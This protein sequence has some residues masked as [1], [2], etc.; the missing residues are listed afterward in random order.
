MSVNSR[1]TKFISNIELTE[2]QKV[3][4]AER[5]EKVIE[6]LNRHYWASSSKTANSKYV[7]S[8]GKLT[9]VRP[10]RDVDVLFQLP[11]S[12]YNR[13]QL[14]TGNRQSQLL[15][16]VKGVLASKFT[17]TAVKGS[18][19]I[20]E[21]PFASYNVEVVPAFILTDKKYWVCMT[22]D[23]GE[24]KVADYD[25]E[26]EIIRASN[27]NCNGNTRNLIRMIKR[28]Q[29]HCDVPIKSFW[30]E[31]IAVE[32]LNQ[33]EYRDKSMTYYDWMVRD[34][35]EF[36]A[37]KEFATLYAPGTYEAMYLGSAWTAKARA[38][39]KHAVNACNDEKDYPHLAGGSWQ[40]IFG[41]DIPLGG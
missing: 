9:R 19:P 4:G 12:V 37:K 10:L 33:W 27:A 8:W 39:H 30:I 23:G 40:V 35:F 26:F 24:Y 11:I 13:F 32:F 38:A 20:V 5:R 36:L 2:I 34:F 1:F 29:A 28:W 16:E 14:R 6:A 22:S 31:L 25:A 18:G 21:V 41:T 7:G 3:S 15:Q 17:T